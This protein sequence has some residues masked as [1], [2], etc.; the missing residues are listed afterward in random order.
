MAVDLDRSISWCIFV[1]WEIWENKMIT[2]L[3]PV[4]L[5]CVILVLNQTCKCLNHKLLYN[6]WDEHYWLHTLIYGSPYMY[7]WTLSQVSILQSVFLES[8]IANRNSILHCIIL[9]CP[10]WWISTEKLPLPFTFMLPMYETNTFTRYICSC[11]QLWRE[12]SHYYVLFLKN[13]LLYKIEHYPV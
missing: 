13:L 1:Y 11:Y 3:Q 9:F 5:L 8:R 7:T 10:R 6:A 12:R 2:L 4:L